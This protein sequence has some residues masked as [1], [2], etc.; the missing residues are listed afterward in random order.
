MSDRGRIGCNGAAAESEAK[1][2]AAVA[3]LTI[4]IAV[5]VAAAPAL[6]TNTPHGTTFITDT[7]G[8]TGHPNQPAVQGNRFITDTLGGDGGAS[9]AQAAAVTRGQTFSWSDA[10]VGGA[11]TGGVL[12]ALIGALLLASHRRSRLA[13]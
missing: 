12:I 5:A 8:G 2:K 10:G 13:T 1:M 3:L 6:A 7:L 11:M 9:P 4:A